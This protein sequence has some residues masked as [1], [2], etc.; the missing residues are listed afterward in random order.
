MEQQQEELTNNHLEVN[1]IVSDKNGSPVIELRKCTNNTEIIK[2]LVSCAYRNEPVIIYPKFNN[3]IQSIN[4][5][6]QKGVIYFCDEEQQYK[7]LI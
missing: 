5:L 2:T 7:Y 4:T 1:L 3:K 6:L